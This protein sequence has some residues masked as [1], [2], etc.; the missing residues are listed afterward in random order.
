MFWF[1]IDSRASQKDTE[2]VSGHHN[3]SEASLRLKKLKK[4]E[5]VLS[6]EI[7]Q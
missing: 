2:Q 1:E 7:W 4:K 5:I 3:S 6:S